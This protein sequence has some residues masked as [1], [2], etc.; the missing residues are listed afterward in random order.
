MRYL[1][2]IISSL[3]GGIL[4]GGVLPN[5]E[6]FG[7]QPDIL[8]ILTLCCVLL[9]ETPVPV[10]FMSIITVFMDIFYTGSVGTY[11]APYAIVTLIA[12][13]VMKSR[14]K[15]RIVVPVVVCAV[16]WLIKD[17]LCAFTV[18]LGG[19][20]F[21]FGRLFLENTLP[22]TL[23]NCILMLI[24]YQLYFKIFEK[25]SIKINRLNSYVEK[26]RFEGASGSI[27]KRSDK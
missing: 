13:W 20:T 1:V 14:K 16:S 7:L 21:E 22:E 8:L 9:D 6:I 24:I 26:P 3:L 17:L 11:T 4:T 10:V 2:F 25:R 23:F 18:F 12:L 5:A 27:Y 19:N 15:D